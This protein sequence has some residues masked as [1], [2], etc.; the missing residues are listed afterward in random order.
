[1]ELDSF[2]PGTSYAYALVRAAYR[3]SYPGSRLSWRKL[4]PALMSA[5]NFAIEHQFKFKL[6][7]IESIFKNFNG[8]FWFGDREYIYTRSCR[9]GNVSA[10]N[11]Y[12]NW[13]GRKPF[14]WDGASEQR[15]YDLGVNRLCVG[16]YFYVENEEWC[17]TSFTDDGHS[18]N[19]VQYKECRAGEPRIKKASRRW[20]IPLSLLRVKRK[21]AKRDDEIKKAQDAME[22][23]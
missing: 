14:R 9:V 13:V 3:G 15:P 7:E 2:A 10:A 22:V 4:N 19:V 17:V 8:A 11:S 12:E 18:V 5:L 20:S 16:A 21:E 1:M 6:G 23:S